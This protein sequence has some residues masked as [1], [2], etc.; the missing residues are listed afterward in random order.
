MNHL[1]LAKSFPVSQTIMEH[2]DELLKRLEKLRELYPHIKYVNWELLRLACLY[3][4]FGK[5]NTKFQNRV[6]SRLG[7]KTLLNDPLPHLKEVHHGYLSPAFLP[8]DDLPFSKNDVKVLCQSIYYHHD[9]PNEPFSV[10]K[11]VIEN[12]LSLYFKNF[13][14]DKTPL[15]TLQ[16]KYSKYIKRRISYEHDEKET[17]HLY[18]MT[19]GLLN[20]IDY[21]ASAN[22]DVEIKNEDL[23][24]R[25][26][27]YIEI[28]G[29]LNH[30]Q[31]Y[32][33]ENQEENNIIV[34]STGIGKTEAALLWIGNN[35]GFFTL[36]L[37]VSINAIYDRIK[38]EVGFQ[39]VGLLHSDTPIEYMKREEEEEF[40]LTKL[41]KTRQM[42][43]PLTI[44][45]LDQLIDL[46][47]RYPGFEIKLATL[48]YSK[49]V[50]DEIQMY[51]PKFVGYLLVAL[52]QLTELGGKFSIITA[53]FPPVFE[54]FMKRLHIPYKKAPKPFFKCNQNGHV[55]KRH[56]MK[57]IHQD[58]SIDD[59][60]EN[61]KD[62]KVLVIVNT[63][64]KAQEVYNELKERL[65]GEN[66][67]LLH[68]RF[69]LKDR[70][71]KE[72][73]ILKMGNATSKEKGIWIT[74][75]IVEA[76]LDIDFD[77]LFTELSEVCGLLQ[78]MGRVYR[79]RCLETECINVYVYTGNPYTSGINPIDS[80]KSIVDPQLFELSK[81]AVSHYDGHIL[82]EEKKMK[83]VESVYNYEV[84]HDSEYYRQIHETIHT[85]EDVIPYEIE[86][87][88]VDLR[89]IE[90]EFMIPLSVYQEN[91]D[92]IE[93]CLKQ[94]QNKLDFKER[95]RIYNELRQYTVSV[96][97]D[98]IQ[99]AK[100]NH[101]HYVHMDLF[102]AIPVVN[103]KY[104]AEKGLLFQEG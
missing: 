84:L 48:S 60:V 82:D 66:V 86:K 49:I 101:S 19:K 44:C 91:I 64:K 28:K 4:D 97:S 67:H 30:L 24:E 15:L 18:I 42:S 54:H 53:T 103:Y 96:R 10:I 38:Q 52:K 2:T 68:S 58:L 36:P 31:K 5:M 46:I 32:M 12:D 37:K 102:N 104:D 85:Y 63:V 9:R 95:L 35:K 55:M 34:A 27:K 40:N 69:I 1:F 65:S 41:E 57:V 75:Q 90:S 76:S 89:E 22:I 26:I 17:V 70:N 11:E 83:L 13:V 23:L 81:E 47:M 43:Y 33:I 6:M 87:R 94:L 59:I 20:K 7:E 92:F 3:H 39:Q 71:K 93:E 56:R 51:S 25:T 98:Y 100:S 50:V 16:T 62:K 99:K 72:A 73:Q 79:N 61:Y 77:I 80:K 29:T 45:T 14:Y 8:L 21:A 88:N 74:T 78:R